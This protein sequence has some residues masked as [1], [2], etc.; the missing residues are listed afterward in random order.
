MEVETERVVQVVDHDVVR[1]TE[2]NVLTNIYPRR[3]RI[4][5]D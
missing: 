4:E 3:K 5:R 1:V 2:K